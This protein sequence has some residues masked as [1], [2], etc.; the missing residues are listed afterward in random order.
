MRALVRPRTSVRCCSGRT[1]RRSAAKRSQRECSTR[2]GS[3]SLPGRLLTST[4]ILHNPS[5][6]G[7]QNVSRRDSV[8]GGRPAPV[9][10]RCPGYAL[11]ADDAPS[12]PPETEPLARLLEAHGSAGRICGRRG[13]APARRHGGPPEARTSPTR[14]FRGRIPAKAWSD[15]RRRRRWCSGALFRRNRAPSRRSTRRDVDTR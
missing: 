15:L 14:R 10:R 2:R 8:A 5:A 4:S 12:L 7:P 9:A 3:G 1:S 13:V 6:A 11:R